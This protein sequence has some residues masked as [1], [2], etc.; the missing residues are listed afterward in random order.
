MIERVREQ[1][2][3]MFALDLLRRCNYPVL[4]TSMPFEAHEYEGGLAETV[5]IP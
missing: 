1:H 5:W 4:E 2:R 3:S